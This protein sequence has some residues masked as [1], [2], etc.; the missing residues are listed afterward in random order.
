MIF[1]FKKVG[2]KNRRVEFVISFKWWQTIVMVVGMCNCPTS[3]QIIYRLERMYRW[4]SAP[5]GT[6]VGI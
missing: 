3:Y 6:I 5:M 4:N 1:S 2:Q